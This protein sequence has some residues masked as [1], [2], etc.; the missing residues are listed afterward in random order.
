MEGNIWKFSFISR[1]FFSDLIV[2]TITILICI[3]KSFIKHTQT[4]T[5][6][7]PSLSPFCSLTYEDDTGGSHQSVISLLLADDQKVG[8]VRRVIFHY[9]FPGRWTRAVSLLLWKSLQFPSGCSLHYITLLKVLLV[10]ALSNYL[11]APPPIFP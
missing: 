8:R 1:S 7:T 2:I 5:H 11:T 9:L 6:T 10:R 3:V 4:H